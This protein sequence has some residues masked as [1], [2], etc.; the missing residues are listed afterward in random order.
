MG[1][2]YKLPKGC[3]K[4]SSFQPLADSSHN[5]CYQQSYSCETS[6]G[7]ECLTCKFNKSTI[8]SGICQPQCRPEQ[9]IIG[10]NC[11]DDDPNCEEW[12]PSGNCKRCKNGSLLYLAT[13]HKPPAN[14]VKYNPQ[15]KKCS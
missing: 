9:K 7:T 5:T 2:C 15:I 10:W 4:F 13:C 14:C 1:R 8:T 12:Y 3:P 11:F 6:S